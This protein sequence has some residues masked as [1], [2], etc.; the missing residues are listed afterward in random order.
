MLERKLDIFLY[1]KGGGVRRLFTYRRWMFLALLAAL[2]LLVAAG[3]YLWQTRLDLKALGNRRLEVL[4]RLAEQKAQSL[5]LVERARGLGEEVARIAS[6]NAKLGTMLDTPSDQG[7]PGAVPRL[8]AASGP[9]SDEE[10]GRRLVDFLEAVGGR[11]AAE[12]LMQQDLEAALAERKLEFLAKPSLWPTKGYITSGFGRRPS[13]FG[14]GGDFHNGVD[15]KV[16]TGTP[17][18]AAGAGRVTDVGRVSGYGLR[19]VISHDYGLET[20][21]AHLKKAEV[22]PGDAVKRGQRIG[23][24]GNSGRTTGAHLHYE[25][26]ADGT[27]VN[28]RLYL[29]D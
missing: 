23:L 21:Y 7:D 24:S 9:T 6:F 2:G 12:E 25:V 19:I 14:R 15:I 20:I 17:V 8:R 1:A 13:P 16:P 26:H 5:R 18:V 28:P 10:L 27:P 4:G 11:L 3:A 29:L 22:T